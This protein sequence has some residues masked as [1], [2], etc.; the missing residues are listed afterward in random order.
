MDATNVSS[1]DA[2]RCRSVLLALFVVACL[3]LGIGSQSALAQAPAAEAQEWVK[4]GQGRYNRRSR[5]TLIRLNAN[6][7]SFVA[8]RVVPL[9]RRV[10]LRNLRLIYRDGTRHDERRR[11]AMRNRQVSLP[12]NPTA[13][14]RALRGALAFHRR[15][16]RGRRFATLELWGLRAPPTPVPPAP[17]AARPASQPASPAGTPALT[18]PPTAATPP[19]TPGAPATTTAALAPPPE[20]PEIPALPPK[21]PP[22]RPQPIVDNGPLSVLV[23]RASVPTAGGAHSFAFPTGFNRLARL[24]L[25]VRGGAINLDDVTLQFGNGESR[26]VA[27]GASLPANRQTIWLALKPDQRLTGVTVRL[28]PRRLRRRDAKRATLDVVAQYR[29]DWLSRPLGSTLTTS[30]AAETRTAQPPKAWFYLGGQSPP[31]F[32][33]RNRVGY[34]TD[35]VRVVQGA[36]ALRALRVDVRNRGITLRALSVTYRDG[37][38]DD[39]TVRRRLPAGSS[40]PVLALKADAPPVQSVELT[41]RTRLADANAAPNARAFV[42]VWGQP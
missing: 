17:V 20:P 22:P 14:P 27:Y 28:N 29:D 3:T 36:M 21:R 2:M 12:I 42:E 18:Q 38:R 5:S 37:S 41:Y 31:L 19:V 34:R 25:Q 1:V 30:A 26:R 10:V 16:R 33:A 13:E 39:F 32:L 15:S 35:K 7:G 23:A 24:R 40:L 11:I 4:I 9:G 6:A 8:Y